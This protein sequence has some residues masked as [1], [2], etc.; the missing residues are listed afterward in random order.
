M[1]IYKVEYSSNNSGGSWWLKDKDWKNLEKAG[2]EIQWVK[3]TDPTSLLSKINKGGRF[4]GALAHDG[5]KSF[6]ANS[7]KEAIGL[8][9]KDWERIIKKDAT[10][11]GCNCCGPPH[12]FT[13]SKKDEYYEYA[14][15]EE[16]LNFMGFDASKT[17]R[18]LLEGK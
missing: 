3:D 7:P 8:A 17:K 9:I 14:S 6:K 11:E 16:L 2:W 12:T 10:E 13:T 18:E 4:L 5:E 15:G 1:K